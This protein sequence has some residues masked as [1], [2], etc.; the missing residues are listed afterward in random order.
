MDYTEYKFTRLIGKYLDGELNP[1]E[2]ENFNSLMKDPL[3]AQEVQLHKDVTGT[4]ENYFAEKEIRDKL[5]RVHEEYCN[6]PAGHEF[7]NIQK[8]KRLWYYMAAAVSGILMIS[9]ILYQVVGRKPDLQ[10][11]FYDNYLAYPVVEQERGGVTGNDAFAGAMTFYKN[12]DYLHAS[13]LLKQIADTGSKNIEA[14]LYLGISYI[15]ENN[16]TDAKEQFLE[17]IESGSPSLSAQA[18]WYHA[19]CRL[20]ENNLAGAREEF[21]A[22]SSGKTSYKAA[23]D[24]IL[25]KI[26]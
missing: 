19:L 10:E 4:L 9:F 20:K 18:S 3:F 23:A 11:I 6:D 1:D 24:K 22:L 5:E 13:L 12:K 7:K 25:D 16:I 8:T 26:K 2:Q 17:I 21:M 15:E 14:R